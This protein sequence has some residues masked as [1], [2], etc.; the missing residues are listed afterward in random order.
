MFMKNVGV[1]SRLAYCMTWGCARNHF[2]IFSCGK[3]LYSRHFWMCFL[4]SHAVSVNGAR[5]NNELAHRH[6]VYAFIIINAGALRQALCAE[7][8]MRA[9]ERRIIRLNAYINGWFSR[10]LY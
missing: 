6:T 10:L 4:S 8:F 2:F 5:H 9:F 7:T 1:L 3:S